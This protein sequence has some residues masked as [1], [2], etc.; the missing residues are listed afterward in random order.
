MTNIETGTS[1]RDLKLIIPANGVLNP[2]A[3]GDFI[4]VKD[5][6][7]AVHVFLHDQEIEMERGDVRKVTRPFEKFTIEN[8]TAND[9][10]VRLVVG[11][12]DYNRLIVQGEMNISAYVRQS[13]GILNE[14]LPSEIVKTMGLVNTTEQ[15]VV[16]SAIKQ[17]SV[18]NTGSGFAFATFIYES[19]Y[20][21]MDNDNLYILDPNAGPFISTQA[22]DWTGV[23]RDGGQNVHC[24][25]VT[26]GGTVYF[27]HGND[28]YKFSLN[29]LVVKLLLANEFGNSTTNLGGFV[30][31][32]KFIFSDFLLVDRVVVYDIDTNTYSVWSHANLRK[33]V[34][35]RGDGYV[36]SA[37][38]GSSEEQQFTVA[39]THVAT[40]AGAAYSSQAST[41]I[42]PDGSIVVTSENTFFR[43]K[44]ARS[45]T[46]YGEVY[47][48]N[49]GDAT[50]RKNIL[51][52]E[53]FE[54]APVL[55]K[56]RMTGRVVRV[57]MRLLSQTEAV[58]YLDSVVSFEWTDGYNTRKVSAGT[59]TWQLREIEDK[60]SILL[61]SEFK[62][63]ILPDFIGL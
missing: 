32:G 30:E 6:A 41:T 29:D 59:Q 53:P 35:G 5:A 60:L 33:S 42:S 26:P 63:E 34:Y 1:Q 13:S 61:D 17:D 24:A 31:A 38:L 49:T 23:V 16:K 39:G 2:N 45:G 62:L 12:G 20:Y 25:G 8:R 19:Q 9:V 36:Y 40:N 56:T 4:F 51:L 55:G 15:T 22:L 7:V 11:F 50:T 14:S 47:I 57:I 58:N 27:K 52:D 43:F 18:A 37:N 28:L 54:W 48:E 3:Q 44:W 46:Y 21:G 10:A